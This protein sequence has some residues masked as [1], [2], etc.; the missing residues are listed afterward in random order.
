MMKIILSLIFTI[1]FLPIFSQAQ[2][3]DK[4]KI[5]INFEDEL[6]R[7]DVKKPELFYL[8]QRKQ[9][10]FKRMIRLREDFLP[11]MRSTGERLKISGGEG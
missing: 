3:G 5:E 9:F 1:L 4:R 2:D 10:N 11:E 7:G 6:I 8:L